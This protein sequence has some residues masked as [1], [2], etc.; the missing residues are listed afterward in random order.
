MQRGDQNGRLYHFEALLFFSV[1][2]GEFHTTSCQLTKSVVSSLVSDFWPKS[3]EAR[4]AEKTVVKGESKACE[5]QIRLFVDS[6]S[7][8]CSSW[9][10]K[11][12]P[13]VSTQ[14]EL[15]EAC[16]IGERFTLSL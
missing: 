13:A 9:T 2:D 4:I 12:V 6:S 3:S 11:V 1:E 15:Y 5:T 14:G 7:I 16:E 10:S 8:V